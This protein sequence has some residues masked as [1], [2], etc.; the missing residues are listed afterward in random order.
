MFCIMKFRHHIF[1]G[2]DVV[3]YKQRFVKGQ[4]VQQLT[5]KGYRFCPSYLDEI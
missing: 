4:T 1:Y 3:A 5:I 2:S